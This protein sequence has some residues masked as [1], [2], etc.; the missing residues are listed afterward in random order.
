MNV[1]RVVISL[2]AIFTLKMASL[3]FAKSA[4][5]FSSKI[6]NRFSKLFTILKNLNRST[7]ALLVNALGFVSFSSLIP[8]LQNMPFGILCLCPCYCPCL[9]PL[10]QSFIL[11]YLLWSFNCCLFVSFC[12]CLFVCLF[13]SCCVCVCVCVCPCP[14]PCT[15]FVLS[16]SLYCFIFPLLP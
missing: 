6:Y 1:L 7:R 9:F 12:A 3:V 2:I 16:L 10:S 15:V 8:I 14:C 13:V 4:D 11:S 5:H